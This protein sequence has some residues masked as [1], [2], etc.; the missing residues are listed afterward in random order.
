[1]IAFK[2]IGETTR[3]HIN[4]DLFM[5]CLL[6]AITRFVPPPLVFSTLIV[7]VGKRVVKKSGKC[8]L[9]ARWSSP[10]CLSISGARSLKEF[11]GG[12]RWLSFHIYLFIFFSRKILCYLYDQK[13]TQSIYISVRE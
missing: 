10:F 13:N 12:R 9:A 6:G 8:S 3:L 11:L 4:F 7:L 5:L 1:M 2:S